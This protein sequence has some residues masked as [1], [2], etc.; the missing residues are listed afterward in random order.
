MVEIL[1]FLRQIPSFLE[2]TKV[3]L[4]IV[5]GLGTNNI[6]LPTKNFKTYVFET[7]F[8]SSTPTFFYTYHSLLP[9]EK[10]GFLEWYMRWKSE[11]ITIPPWTTVSGKELVLGKDV[12]RKEVFP[13]KS[14]S[15]ILYSK[16]FSVCY[17][18][19]FAD[20]TFTKATGK[21]AEIR[22]IK[23]FSEIFPLS[24]CDF[25]FIYWPSADLILHERFKDC[26][27]EA[28]L[29]TLRFYISLLWKK[30]PR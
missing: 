19:P 12:K 7:V 26:A 18:T 30:I 5:D 25:T 29:Q 27:F 14:L 23:Y 8:P 2:E 6:K 10:H 15:E 24:E 22:K 3:F 9:P 13:F 21:Y 11:I 17:Y 28:E 4:L 1:K 20:S 16:G